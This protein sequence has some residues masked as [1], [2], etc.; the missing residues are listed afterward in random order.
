MQAGDEL[1]LALRGTPG[2]QA[3]ASVQG[4]AKRIAL[5]EVRPGEYEASYVVRRKDSLRG[6]V[7]ADGRLMVNRHAS[8]LHFDAGQPGGQNNGQPVASCLHCGSVV[9]VKQVNIK[10]ESQNVIGTIAGGVLG[11]VLGN[12]VGGGTGRDLATIAGAVGGAYAGNRVE[13]NMN[14]K[15][16]TRVNVR[17]DDGSTRNFDYATDPGLKAGTRVKV[18]NNALVRL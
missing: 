1:V 11:G 2:G 10:G 8:T 5:S 3:S 14:K 7:V 6:R 18:D 9:S 4:V 17:L 13:N 16:V 15:Q 12:Q